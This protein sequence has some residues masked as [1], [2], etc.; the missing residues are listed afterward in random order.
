MG[1]ILSLIF[2]G[3]WRQP[4]DF[5]GRHIEQNGDVL[6]VSPDPFAR[7]PLDLAL[8]VRRVP[9][10]RYESDAELRAALTAAPVEWLRGT[11]TGR[12]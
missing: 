2:C 4:Y 8:E 11:A 6:T 9:L 12:G 5:D 7:Q 10:Q 3:G 1:D